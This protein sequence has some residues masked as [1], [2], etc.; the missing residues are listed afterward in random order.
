[1][2]AGRNVV[3]AD[4][5]FNGRQLVKLNDDGSHEWLTSLTLQSNGAP[6]TSVG[7]KMGLNVIGDTVLFDAQ[8][9]G[10]DTTLWS[11]NMTKCSRIV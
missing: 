4:D 1:M 10:V 9:S 8:T 2:R 11:Y 5:G 3:I 7:E 6:T